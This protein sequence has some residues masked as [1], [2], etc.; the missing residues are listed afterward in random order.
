MEWSD[1]MNAVIDYIEENLAGKI[2]FNKAA[3]KA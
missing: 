3:E 1:R 2:D